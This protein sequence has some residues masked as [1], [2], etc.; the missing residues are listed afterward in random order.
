[1]KEI[2]FESA[3]FYVGQ[4]CSENDELFKSMPGNSTWFHLDSQSSSH[5]YCVSENKKLT[6]QEIKKG[7][8]L[9]RI[10]SKKSGK[11]IYLKKS[12]LKRIGPGLVEL[13]DDPKYT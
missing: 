3:I 5:V 8:E 12:K 4:N 11:V 10:W 7:A 13:L 1:M 6:K 9:V 2:E